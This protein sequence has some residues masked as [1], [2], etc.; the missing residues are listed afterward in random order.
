MLPQ[1]SLS[2]TQ[3]PSKNVLKLSG[4]LKPAEDGQTEFAPGEVIVKFKKKLNVAVD[5]SVSALNTGSASL[6][7]E[8]KQNKV[9]SM[10]QVFSS[11]VQTDSKYND[12]EKNDLSNIYVIK[13]SAAD[14][15]VSSM[16]DSYKED[17]NVEYAEP[18]YIYKPTD[19]ATNDPL[20]ST[21]WA[22]AK[23]KA[24]LAWDTTTGSSNVVV[25]VVDTGTDYTHQDLAA[26][27][28]NNPGET[29]MTQVGDKC[30]TGTPQDKSTNNCDDDNDG[31]V[32]DWRGWNYAEGNNDPMDKGYQGLFHGTHVSG[33][34]AGVGNNGIGISGVTWNSKIMPLR[35]C[36]DSGCS[37][38]SGGLAI[39]YAVDH[40]AKVINDSWGGAT[41]YDS[42]LKDSMDYAHDHGALIVNAAGN[43]SSD[44]Y[45]TVPA[46]IASAMAVSATDSSDNFAGF[47]NWGAKIDVSA[48]GVD[49]NSTY[50]T[51]SY[52]SF[53]GTSM[54]APHVAGL[55]ALILAH[56]PALSVEELRQVIKTSA[57]DLGDAGV[58]K[59]FGAGRIDAYNAMM[60][61][62]PLTA[63]ISYPN[64]A[65][66]NINGTVNITGTA[67]GT[68]F[69][70]YVL[71]YGAGTNPSTWTQITTSTTPVDNGTLATF[72]LGQLRS[73]TYVLRLTAIDTN[74][75]QYQFV[76]YLDVVTNPMVP[77]SFGVVNT[78]SSIMLSWMAPSSQYPIAG[79][80][81]Y[82]SESADFSNPTIFTATSAVYFDSSFQTGHTYYYKVRAYNNQTPI[83]YSDFT[84]PI[85]ITRSNTHWTHQVSTQTGGG[86]KSYYTSYVSNPSADGR[87]IAF[88]DAS[89]DLVPGDNNNKIDVFVKDIV[90]NTTTRV[91]VS[92]QGVEGNDDSNEPELSSD[93]RYVVFSSYA[94]NLVAN[95]NNNGED[96]FVHD[97]Q[98]GTT[99]LVSSDTGGVINPNWLFAE[100][101]S[102]SADGRYVTFS[103]I[104]KSGPGQVYRKDLQTGETD[105]VSSDSTGIR[106][107][108]SS[109]D[110]GMST[111]GRYIAFDSFATNLVA[112]NPN[113]GNGDIYLKD[114]QTGIT[115][116]ISVG[117]G[118]GM[119][120][121]GVALSVSESG[122]YVV[123][124][125]GYEHMISGETTGNIIN[126]FLR[127]RQNGI[128]T[129]VSRSIDGTD[130]GTQNYNGKIS[131]DGRFVAFDSDATNLVAGDGD[132]HN[133]LFLYDV[134]S[135]TMKLI[136]RDVYGS[137][138][139]SGNLLVSGNFSYGGKFIT[140]VSDG[141]YVV[142]N[143]QSSQLNAYVT[144]VDSD[145]GPLDH[146]AISPSTNQSIK[147]GQS[148]QFNAQGQDEYNSNIA[149]LS[150]VWTGADQT[151][152]FT[153]STVGAYQVKAS[154]GGIDSSSTSVTV[155]AVDLA[156]AAP[157]ALSV[158]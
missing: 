146:I 157:S 34:I 53:S 28:W 52:Q 45:G 154:S 36:N 99:T 57:D 90:T 43:E 77:T 46:N 27:I 155:T 17:S 23:I 133:D 126:V 9:D 18:D 116:L 40:G 117:S 121:Y 100:Y 128:T 91:S 38:Y 97:M 115:E 132:G 101:P 144:A 103:T 69:Q 98:L 8:N 25:A 44:V 41:S 2:D 54:A 147:S 82:K 137:E 58:D 156:P 158:R 14:V 78:N 7:K 135:A 94:S 107:N 112:G 70:S 60:A 119:F 63:Y 153:A 47:S 42:F 4:T 93:G 74:S 10:K 19:T 72:D 113:G 16:V 138:I 106:G 118:G 1:K 95:D 75:K 140:F 88:S 84:D 80:Q 31:L 49:V 148:L 83:V 114:M 150:Y 92:T 139:Y 76:S 22:L 81:I 134:N 145:A 61:T 109:M 122:R 143:V 20:F 131:S 39:R 111:D 30:W 50:P 56:N 105:V 13:T 12:N 86:Q 141:S 29:G 55:A 149:G 142:P 79:Y 33:I 124:S 65:G 6:N 3:I 151:G 11:D 110:S 73:G 48:P 104:E 89:S 85:I 62:T 96:I 120:Q 152:L 26:N 87:Y 15:D 68:N 51:N 66:V 35:I 32:D 102:F 136:S 67:S 129:L 24:P 123:F 59:Y 64:S 37:S 71:E 127:D 108:N 130:A 21:Q 5:G 125:S